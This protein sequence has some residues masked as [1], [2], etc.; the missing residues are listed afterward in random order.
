MF[1]N[2][3]ISN[4]ERIS[5]PTVSI[6]R[7]TVELTESSPGQFEAVLA[8]DYNM[9]AGVFVSYDTAPAEF[10]ARVEE[11]TE[12]Q[13]EAQ[14]AALAADWG[15]VEGSV[16]SS[17]DGPDPDATYTPTY[18]V[19]FPDKNR[20]EAEVRMSLKAEKLGGAPVPYRG[21]TPYLDSTGVLTVKGSISRAALSQD[22]LRELAAFSPKLKAL[23]DP[24]DPL[25]TDYLGIAIS[26]SFP[27]GNGGI[28]G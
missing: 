22:Q 7:Q 2:V 14:Q 27:Q 23:A 15:P 16:V 9:G 26:V 6:G 3:H 21:F 4:A 20:T 1:F 5:K 12:E 25:S 24:G 11:P 18:K 28:R 10:Q 19:V 13:W 8:P 17:T